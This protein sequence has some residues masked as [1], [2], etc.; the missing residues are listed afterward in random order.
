MSWSVAA[1]IV[2]FIGALACLAY[3]DRGYVVVTAIIIN[4]PAALILFFLQRADYNNFKDRM[5]N[6]VSGGLDLL[7]MIG[8]P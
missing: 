2:V 5:P 1:A 3:V 7:V 6:G 4:A 8:L